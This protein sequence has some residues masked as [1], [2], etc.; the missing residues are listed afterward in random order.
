M[1]EAFEARIT[2]LSEYFNAFS[3][4][5]SSNDVRFRISNVFSSRFF[6]AFASVPECFGLVTH[7]F[8]F[9]S[10]AHAM[11]RAVKWCTVLLVASLAAE[12]YVTL[13][14]AIV[15]ALTIA[16]TICWAFLFATVFAIETLFAFTNFIDAF[17]VATAPF[18]IICMN[19]TI[20]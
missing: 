13:T 7:T 17:A 19:T 4:S 6:A 8:H 2:E 12:T 20:R 9:N 11:A 16:V 10:I 3:F 15:A 14:H 1:A 5:D 18:R